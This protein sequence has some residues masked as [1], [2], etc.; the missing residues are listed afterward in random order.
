MYWGEGFPMDPGL[1]TIPLIVPTMTDDSVCP[2]A[3]MSFS[4]VASYHL[5]YVSGLRASPAMQQFF[6]DERSYPSTP[7]FR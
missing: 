3:S 6:R 1:G 2:N 7:A 5:L 4:P